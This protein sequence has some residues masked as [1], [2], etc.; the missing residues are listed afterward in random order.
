MPLLLA[1]CGGGGPHGSAGG[2]STLNFAEN[3][4]HVLVQRLGEKGP[5]TALLSLCTCKVIISRQHIIHSAYMH[6]CMQHEC[7][8]KLKPTLSCILKNI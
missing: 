5:A 7:T 1:A 4:V 3:E 6:A 2:I 8:A